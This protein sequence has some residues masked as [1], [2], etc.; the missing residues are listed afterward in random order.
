M[1]GT[2]TSPPCRS[3]GQA[4][5]MLPHAYLTVIRHQALEQGDKGAVTASMQ[6]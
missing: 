2:G 1:A 3:T 4:L 6:N 5:A